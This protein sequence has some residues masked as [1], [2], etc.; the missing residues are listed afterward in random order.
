MLYQIIR[1]TLKLLSL[2]IKIQYFFVHLLRIFSSFIEL[3]GLVIFLPVIL[4]F[5]NQENSKLLSKFS[6]YIDL[7]FLLN[8]NLVF[9]CYIIF[10]VFLLKNTILVIF[11]IIIL[12]IQ[13]KNS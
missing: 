11:N 3:L 13:K 1:K 2:K 6:Y 5:T 8:R 9:Y 12:K 7:D 10:L 4:I